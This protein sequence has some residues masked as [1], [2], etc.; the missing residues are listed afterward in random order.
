MISTER[1]RYG[2]FEAYCQVCYKQRKEFGCMVDPTGHMWRVC[3]KCI[4]R[5][6]RKRQALRNEAIVDV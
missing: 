2:K 5:L 1:I 3:T 4:K 6:W